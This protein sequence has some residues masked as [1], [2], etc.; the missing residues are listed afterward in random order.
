VRKAYKF[1]VINTLLFF[2]TLDFGGEDVNDKDK[3]H[4]E[5]FAYRQNTALFYY[6]ITIGIM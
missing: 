6:L 2:L 5:V 3:L 4:L 1:G